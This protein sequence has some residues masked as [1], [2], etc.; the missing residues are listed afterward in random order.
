MLRIT[1]LKAFE[2]IAL[3]ARLIYEAIKIVIET[4]SKKG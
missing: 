1:L 4:L 3:V 2:I